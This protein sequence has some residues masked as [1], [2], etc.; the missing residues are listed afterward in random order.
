MTMS[1]KVS[2]NRR[3]NRREKLQARSPDVSPVNFKVCGKLQDHVL[4]DL[5]EWNITKRTMQ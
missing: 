1:G 3:F 5:E 2:F 4:T